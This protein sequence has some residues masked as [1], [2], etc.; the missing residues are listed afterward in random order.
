MQGCAPVESVK[1]NKWRWTHGGVRAVAHDSLVEIEPD[2]RPSGGE[3]FAI[4]EE[5]EVGST[6]KGRSLGFAT[7]REEQTLRS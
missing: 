2:S 3:L 1:S 4:G 7:R 6:E 5:Q